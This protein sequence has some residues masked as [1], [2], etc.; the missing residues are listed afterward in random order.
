[1]R[2]TFG[3]KIS[4]N[5]A[6]ECMENCEDCIVRKMSSLRAL[7]A[8]ELEILNRS[9]S[10]Y[11]LRKGEAIFSEG[12]NINGIFCIKE[13][14]CKMTKLSANGNEQVV[15]LTASGELLGQRSMISDE[16]VGLSAVALN[17][18]EVCYIPK[19]T[20]MEFFNQNNQFSLT[21]MKTICA[22]LKEANNHLVDMAQKS[23]R[24]RLAGTLLY[25][26]ES[27]GTDEDGCLR[28]KLSREEL[29]GIIGTA[30]ESCIRLLS[31]FQKAGKIKLEG[32]NI[33]LT[34]V[35]A[36]TILNTR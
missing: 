5:F 23:V 11:S 28:I 30:T 24:Q 33:L 12:E 29:A 7:T 2:F 16:A 36:L 20:V 34:D 26:Y 10:S 9:K 17:P 31:E 18:M 6:T 8:D 35:S 21:V 32:K 27:F 13:G 19:D 4:G 14:V 1:V 3:K 22:D 15:R 25:L